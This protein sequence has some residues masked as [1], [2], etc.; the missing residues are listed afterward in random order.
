[1]VILVRLIKMIDLFDLYDRKQII[2][3]FDGDQKI[4]DTNMNLFDP[5]G[6]IDIDLFD[7]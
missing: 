2:D 5:I 3:L 1:M 6:I 4:K 7:L